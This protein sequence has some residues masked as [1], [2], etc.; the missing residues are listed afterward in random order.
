MEKGGPGLFSFRQVGSVH[1][2]VSRGLLRGRLYLGSYLGF[3][4]AVLLVS[5]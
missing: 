4:S 2:A 1:S 5:A 3:T